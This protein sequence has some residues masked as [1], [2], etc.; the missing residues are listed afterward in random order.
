MLF[1]SAYRKGGTWAGLDFGRYQGEPIAAVVNRACP[2]PV[3]ANLTN[4]AAYSGISSDMEG[5]LDPVFGGYMYYAPLIFADQAGL[6]SVIHIQNSGAK[7]TSLEIWFKAQ[8]NCMRSILGDVLTV[9]PGETVTFDPNTVVGPGWVGSAWIRG[10]QPLGIVVDTM[11]ANHFT[12]YNGVAAD[13]WDLDWSYGNDVNF[14]PLIYSEYQGWDTAIQV[15]NLSALYSAKVKVYFLDRSGD[16]ITT[17]VDWICPRGSQTFFL[18]LIDAIPGNWVGS[19]RIESQ[20][21]VTPG[22]PLV[23]P[24][25]IASV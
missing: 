4:H 21:W 17:L 20:E 22:G 5:A 6:K 24:P 18:P 10:S 23:D 11:G 2:D 14:A 9:A 1:D 3:D 25:R 7:C 16:V 13:V 19:A 15:Q 8:D 12:S